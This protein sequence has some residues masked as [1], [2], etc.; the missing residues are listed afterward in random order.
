MLE[1]VPGLI[2][3]GEQPT[4][5]SC[6]LDTAGG[7]RGAPRAPK[8]GRVQREDKRK[9]LTGVRRE[10]QSEEVRR[11]WDCN[12]RLGSLFISFL[13]SPLLQCGHDT[14]QGGRREWKQHGQT[15]RRRPYPPPDL[16]GNRKGSD[17]W[18][19]M[20]VPKEII[21]KLTVMLKKV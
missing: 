10:R 15:D 13:N 17:E 8:A 12:G 5:S 16:K 3:Q 1:E 4:H 20:D 9:E 14:V 11:L 2:P 18:T 19:V 6:N 21:V 7:V